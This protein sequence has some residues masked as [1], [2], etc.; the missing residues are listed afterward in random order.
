MGGGVPSESVAAALSTHNDWSDMANFTTMNRIRLNAL[1]REHGL[2]QPLDDHN[3]ALQLL[4]TEL[5][6][7]HAE[8]TLDAIVDALDGHRIHLH[9]PDDGTSWKSCV[10]EEVAF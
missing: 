6:L 2:D 5:R 3:L 4:D 10:A 7:K 8:Q 1:L 9:W